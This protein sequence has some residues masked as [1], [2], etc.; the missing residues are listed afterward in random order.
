MLANGDNR[1]MSSITFDT[2][3]SVKRLIAA[4]MPESQAEA[5]TTMVQEVRENDLYQMATKTDLLLLEQRITIKLGGLIV[6]A[7]GLI[8]AGI[9]YLH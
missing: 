2:H 1:P 5:V 4:G 8:L 7:T 3:A 9:R 6:A